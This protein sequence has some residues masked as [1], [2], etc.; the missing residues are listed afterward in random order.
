MKFNIMLTCIL[1]VLL[2]AFFIGCMDNQSTTPVQQ[3]VSK[4]AVGSAV[5]T[6]IPQVVSLEKTAATNYYQAWTA[7]SG[8]MNAQNLGNG[9]YTVTWSNVGDIVVGTGYNP[10]GQQMTW[11]GSQ[12]GASYFGV[13][14]WCN[15]PL[16]EYYIGRGGGNSVGSYSVGTGSYTLGTVS[17]NGAN[18]NGNGAFQQFNCS[19]NGGSGITPSD[20]FSKWGGLG[21]GVSSPNYCIVAIEAWNGSSGNANVTVGGGGGGGSSSSSSSSSG[22]S[23]SGSYTINVQMRGTSGSEH[24]YLKVG[25]T[26]IGSWTLGTSYNTYAAS[27]T[28][29][30]GI[31]VGFDNDASGRDVQVNCI[32]TPAGQFMA[33]NQSTNTGVYQN[34]KCG[35][36]N[37]QWLN[38]NGYIGFSAYR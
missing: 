21:H 12:S 15:S 13:Y 24:A 29:S 25:S 37:S 26:Q 2:C 8:S 35:G 6:K 3:G 33:A 38:C 31:L 14:G 19:G 22:G 34:S 36:S 4:Q 20:H 11:T 27:T 9:H 17:C 30:G 23:G 10:G 28:A 1:V 32:W 16:T 18:I 5:A 7:G